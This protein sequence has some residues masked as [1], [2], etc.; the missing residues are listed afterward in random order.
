MS[1]LARLSITVHIDINIK[2]TIQYST[3][4]RNTSN[5]LCGSNPFMQMEKVKRVIYTYSSH[6]YVHVV[7]S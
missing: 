3:V 2:S 1:R 4:T 6:C 5:L 7:N